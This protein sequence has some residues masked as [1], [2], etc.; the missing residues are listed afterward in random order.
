MPI[1]KLILLLIFIF[2]LAASAFEVVGYIY[3]SD[4]VSHLTSDIIL[5]QNQSIKDNIKKINIIAP[6]AYQI[7]EKG[8]LWGS[9]DPSILNLTKHHAVKIMPLVTNADFDSKKTDVF[10]NNPNA[11]QKAINEMVQVCKKNHFV[12]FQIDFEHILLT[13]KNAFTRFYQ[14]AAASLHANHF[15]ISVAIIPRIT[16]KI[17]ASNRERS[18]LEFWNGGYDYAA[19]GKA[20]D[21]VTLMAYD[22]HSG[23][24]TPGS[25]CEPSWLKSIIVYALKTI[26]ANKIFIGVPVHSSYWYTALGHGDLYV[27]ESDL[28]YPQADY[29]L[30][31]HHVKLVWN[32]KSDVPYAIF[33]ENNLNRYLFVQNTATFKTQLALAEKYK[34]R[35]VSLWCLGYEDPNIWKVI[36]A[37]K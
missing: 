17:P 8:T 15:L 26:P 7:N 31:D 34:L 20:S 14:N 11:Q 19:L 32:K 4:S 5:R 29:L 6:Q 12:G 28:S 37:K 13:D 24:T 2:P 27:G 25:A 33:S 30:K 18:A 9:V 10:L 3:R 35:G 16:N 36:A 1:K 23:G 21:F 22:Q